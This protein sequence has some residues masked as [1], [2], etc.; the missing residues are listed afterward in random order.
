MHC[1]RKARAARDSQRRRRHPPRHLSPGVWRAQPDTCRSAC[2]RR[3]NNIVRSMGPL[4]TRRPSDSL[5][6]SY[7]TAKTWHPA[8]FWPKPQ[9]GTAVASTLAMARR[10]AEDQTRKT[11]GRQSEISTHTKV[12]AESSFDT[13]IGA[14][15]RGQTCPDSCGP[16]ARASG[17][18]GGCSRC[19]RDRGR[20]RISSRSDRQSGLLSCGSSWIRART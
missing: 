18:A 13:R 12:S 15:L 6:T 20:L 17:F 5:M 2:A 9:P 16:A 10:T 3:S 11:N 7:L 8:I 4:S 19:H 1:E 14:D